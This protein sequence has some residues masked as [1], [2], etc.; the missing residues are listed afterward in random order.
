MIEYHNLRSQFPV[1][2]YVSGYDVAKILQGTFLDDCRSTALCKRTSV[3]KSQRTVAKTFLWFGVCKV[4]YHN[5]RGCLRKAWHRCLLEKNH[6]NIWLAI[7]LSFVPIH[8]KQVEQYE[9]L[10]L[11]KSISL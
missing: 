1:L 4:R 3:K 9:A 6:I 10:S 7:V 2:A 11:N 5:G 8:E